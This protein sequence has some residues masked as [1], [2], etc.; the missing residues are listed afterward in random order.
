M[1]KKLFA[2]LIICAILWQSVAVASQSIYDIE[3]YIILDDG[4]IIER[5]LPIPAN[6]IARIA[7]SGSIHWNVDTNFLK[8]CVYIALSCAIGCNESIRNI[9]NLTIQYSADYDCYFLNL[10]GRYMWNATEDIPDRFD[11]SLLLKNDNNNLY[12][13]GDVYEKEPQDQGII[14][15]IILIKAGKYGAAAA[16]ACKKAVCAAIAKYLCQGTLNPPPK[17]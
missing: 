15:I 9:E 3:D 14:Q 13:C 7:P 2:N 5:V 1:L 6:R 16:L 17:N 11:I 4:T 8:H 12:V 10:S